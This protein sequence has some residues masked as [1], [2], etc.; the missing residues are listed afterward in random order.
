MWGAGIV[1]VSSFSS[2]E[3][4][5]RG[6]HE[7]RLDPLGFGAPHGRKWYLRLCCCNVAEQPLILDLTC[8]VTRLGQGSSRGGLGLAG[9]RGQRQGF[10]LQALAWA[11]I[12]IL[13]PLTDKNW[14]AKILLGSFPLLTFFSRSRFAIKISFGYI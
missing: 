1:F 11:G 13:V 12:S 10:R 5:M 8:D 4:K 7:T 2:P 14:A 3:I 6:D 9:A